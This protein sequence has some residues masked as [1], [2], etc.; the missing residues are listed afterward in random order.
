[1][2]ARLARNLIALLFVILYI[3][4]AATLGGCATY[5]IS[6]CEGTV[7]STANI[8]SPRKFA[9]INFKYNGEQRTFELQAGEVGTDVSALNTLAGVIMMQQQQMSKE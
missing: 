9:S 8:V 3:A 7:C 6:R 5:E 1:M 2:S 4:L